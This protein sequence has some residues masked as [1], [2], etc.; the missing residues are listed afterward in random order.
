[1]ASQDKNRSEAEVRQL[2]DIF[3]GGIQNKDIDRVMSCY[4]PDLVA[5]DLMPPLEYT[6]A[7]EYR[8]SWQMAFNMTEG[9]FGLERR[10]LE[11]V[12]ADDVAF[13]H[14]I[15][16]VTAS[17]KEGDRVDMWLRWTACFRRMDGG[18]KIVH[19]HGSVPVDME[20]DKA[21]WNLKPR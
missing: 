14:A 3:L 4:A 8:K 10:D 17:P 9:P 20:T 2:I 18:W 16:H 19:E 6:S 21:V 7:A 12:A 15:D 13:A 5:F 11:V 1:M